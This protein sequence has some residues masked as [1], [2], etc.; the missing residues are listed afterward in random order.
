MAW[1]LNEAL[2]DLDVLPGRRDGALALLS[3]LPGDAAEPGTDAHRELREFLRESGLNLDMAGE[4]EGIP[5]AYGDDIYAWLAADLTELVR[6]LGFVAPGSHTLTPL[7]KA[8]REEAV[9]LPSGLAA[10]L[11]HWR[12]PSERGPVAPLPRLLEI[13]RTLDSED[14]KP[15]PGLLLPEFAL[16]MRGL[17]RGDSESEGWAD[18]YFAAARAWREK[19]TASWS[20]EIPEPLRFLSQED[21]E[22]L[23]ICAHLESSPGET[24][25]GTDISRARATLTNILRSGFALYGG[26]VFLPGQYATSNRALL[27]SVRRFA[28]EAPGRTLESL[29]AANFQELAVFAKRLDEI[30]YSDSF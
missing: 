22:R 15:C 1:H 10:G 19:A 14:W 12:I 25:T 17:E 16:T 4:E 29:V 11:L 24:I 3:G 6:R 26:Q 7:G 21:C 5:E 2:T 9:S 18:E 8:V 20:G 27:A 28:D 23:A 30:W 13:L